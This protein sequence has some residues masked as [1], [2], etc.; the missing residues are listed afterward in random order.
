MNA[1][2]VADS[3]AWEALPADVKA[4]AR[5]LLG[6]PSYLEKLAYVKGYARGRAD[7]REFGHFQT[8]TLPTSPSNRFLELSNKARSRADTTEPHD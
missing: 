8:V 2:S 1:P 4:L 3:L 5:R 7:A 6:E